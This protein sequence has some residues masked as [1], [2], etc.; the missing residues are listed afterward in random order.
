MS[1]VAIYPDS[2][3]PFT[4]GHLNIIVKYVKLLL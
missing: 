3:D 1:N 4:Y 2:F